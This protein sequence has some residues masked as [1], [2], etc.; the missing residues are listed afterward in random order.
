MDDACAG[1]QGAAKDAIAQRSQCKAPDRQQD[2]CQQVLP[3]L[4]QGHATACAATG[5]GQCRPFIASSSRMSCC[6]VGRCPASRLMQRVIR[7][8][9]SCNG[10]RVEQGRAWWDAGRASG[11]GAARQ[12]GLD[13]QAGTACCMQGPACV[14]NGQTEAPK[15]L[16]SNAPVDTRPAHA[17][18]A[19]LHA[20]VAPAGTP[21]AGGGQ[22]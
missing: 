19:S 10:Q 11:G 5:S 15:P 6:A 16:H 1:R 13:D 7:S 8:A 21:A 9:A 22:G 18:A 2:G 17:A 14:R 12:G 3:A 20:R 4:Q